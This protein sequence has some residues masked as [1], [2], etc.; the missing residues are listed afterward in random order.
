MNL[1]PRRLLAGTALT[2]AVAACSTGGPAATASPSPIA[3]PAASATAAAQAFSIRTP[4]I[5]PQAC[6]DAL[7]GGK[8]SRVAATG[9]GITTTDGQQIAVEWPF[10]YSAFDVDGRIVLRD[11]T[12]TVVAREGDEITVG[13]GLGNDLW[14]A[15]GPV[16]VTK[17]AG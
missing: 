5:P 13:G 2:L 8:L 6:M 3:T 10:R 11:E 14:Y 4:A 15:R 9:L 16:S 12:G 1:L 7:M 17:A